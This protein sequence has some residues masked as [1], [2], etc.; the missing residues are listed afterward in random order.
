ML[1]DQIYDISD[2]TSTVK[3]MYSFK[4]AWKFESSLYNTNVFVFC[5][6]KAIN[7]YWSDLITLSP[8][9]FDN[10][11]PE[12][13]DG[14]KISTCFPVSVSL[15]PGQ[16]TFQA[17]SFWAPTLDS[18]CDVIVS[19][20]IVRL[21]GVGWILAEVKISGRECAGCPSSLPTG[22]CQWQSTCQGETNQPP[23]NQSNQPQNQIKQRISEV[24]PRTKRQSYPLLGLCDQN[25]A[26]HDLNQLLQ[27]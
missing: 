1:P 3:Y 10:L 8:P 11:S 18:D 7:G 13:H 24:A 23:N 27:L 15:A 2:P 19:R 5:Q 26:A 17:S 22:Q 20:K 4:L 12:L 6:S 21:D 9:T 14:H 16:Q 25:P